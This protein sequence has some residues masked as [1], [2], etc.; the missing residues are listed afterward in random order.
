MLA[1]FPT[2]LNQSSWLKRITILSCI[3]LI[4]LCTACSPQNGNG[5]GNSATHGIKYGG[6]LTIVPGPYG[7]FN[8]YFNPFSGDNAALSGTRGMIYETL[9][10]FNQEKN[11]IQPWLATGFSWSS[12]LTRLTFKLRQG[13]QWS[14]GQPFTSDDV[15]F[16]LNL[17]HQ[18]PALDMNTMWAFIKEVANPDAYTV[19]ITFK[20]PSV[21]EQW[22]LG[23]QT[24]IVPRHIWQRFKDPVHEAN[25]DPVGTGPFM[26]KSFDPTLYVLGRNPRYWQPGKPY[27]DELRYPAYTS[28][29]SA[30]LLLAQGS[31]DWTGLFSSNLQG[32][33]VRRD[34]LNNHYWLPPIAVVTLYLNTAK[35]PFQQLAVRQAIS[36]AINR[37]QLSQQGESGYEP[38]AHPTALVLPTN[39]QF[40]AQPYS[41][42][43][44]QV[45]TARAIGLLQAAGFSRGRD[46]IFVDKQG[47][48]LAFTMNV[49]AGWTDWQT[50]CKLMAA[51]LKA[52]GIDVTVN[53]MSLKAYLSA[54]QFGSF[55][56]AISWTTSGPSPYF[57]YYA[58]LASGNTAPMGKQATSNWERWNDQTTD[59]LLA[60]YAHSLSASAQ[61]Q[62]LAGLQ[63]IMV[64]QLPSIP[65]LYNVNWYEYTTARFTGWPDQNNPYAVPS[66]YA[67]P[68]SEQVALSLRKV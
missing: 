16:T 8:R 49:V 1:Y 41:N 43:S 35:Y 66:P 65:L 61:Q 18:Y 2:S 30:N 48:R 55:D 25:P 52:I 34:P 56:T 37:Q 17:L 64:E 14:D 23:G 9:M 57:L 12:D 24:Y 38:S 20:Q 68:D 62:A 31:I 44:F 67:Y 5:N 6:A 11:T 29:A 33:F 21:P 19:I 3:V 10:F 22:Y 59:Q 58:L 28:N 13:V 39:R 60:Q 51:D 50:D 53:A 42:L 46:G 45:D 26:L 15:V 47:G 4:I 63:R 40:L 32:N 7:S 27:I 54:L 36:L